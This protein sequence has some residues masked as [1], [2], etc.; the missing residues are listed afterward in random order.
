MAEVE[1]A[2]VQMR[3]ELQAKEAENWAV[4]QEMAE[5]RHAIEELEKKHAALMQA[6]VHEE[7]ASKVQ[8]KMPGAKAQAHR[9]SAK[10]QGKLPVR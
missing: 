8:E 10:A 7:V 5:V 1:E 9:M 6:K 3:E 2:E 4:Q